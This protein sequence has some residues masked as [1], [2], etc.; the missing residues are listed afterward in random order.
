MQARSS[1]H[2]PSLTPAGQRVLAAFLTGRLPAGRLHAELLHAES[3]RPA[4]PR[5]V[6]PDD[7]ASI[8]VPRA[9]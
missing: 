3:A 8:P 1:T 5:L 4:A 6:L 2:E 7:T 9:A